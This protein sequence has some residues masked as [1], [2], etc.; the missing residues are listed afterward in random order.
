MEITKA[1][2]YFFL[3][4]LAVAS[5]AFIYVI[6]PFFYPIF[7]AAV[8]ASVF[9]PVY[10][11]V[12]RLLNPNFSSALTLILITIMF[13]LPFSFFITL[14]AR[15]IVIV[16]NSYGQTNQISGV[17][18]DVGNFLRTNEQIQKLGINDAVLT[19]RLDEIGK[20]VV[21]F[22]YQSLK[23]FTQNSVEFL[24]MFILMLYSLFFFLR[25]GE[26]IMKKIM[27][28]LP[29]GSK[30]E[31]LLYDKFTSAASAA[32]KG[33][34][35]VSVIQGF[36]GG[37]LFWATGIPGALIW[38]IVMSALATIPLTGTYIVWLP[39]ALLKIATGQWLV[40]VII[41]SLGTLIVSTIDNFLRPIIIGKEL[42]MHPVVILFAT[43]G[44][45]VVFGLTGFVLGPIIA[46]LCQSLW[47]L[48]EHYYKDELEKN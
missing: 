10:K 8:L 5:V 31:K 3:G 44:G 7:W 40:G 45:L 25:D 24:I 1:K 11:R 33:T 20:A 47:E 15:Q 22:V 16:F 34:L 6:R 28:I 13:I 26:K 21:T 2:Q 35:I 46:A 19:Q 27:F 32:I 43:L 36:L 37:L 18:N 42:S 30:N 39:V 38:G 17:I 48:Y 23:S 29:L 9:Y 14:L 4:S 41:L 12:S